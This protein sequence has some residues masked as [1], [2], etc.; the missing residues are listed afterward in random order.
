MENLEHA[1]VAHPDNP[2]EHIEVREQK[3]LRPG[4]FG[5]LMVKAKVDGSPT[6]LMIDNEDRIKRGKCLCGYYRKFGLKN[7]PCRHMIALRWGDVDVGAGMI[8][9][10]DESTTR[11]TKGKRQPGHS[12]A[13]AAGRSRSPARARSSPDRRHASPSIA[14]S[15]DR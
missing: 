6:E 8:R 10:V 2:I 4:G 9:L 5:I 3:G 1:A 12:R 14:R 7:G 13:A 15:R 11:R